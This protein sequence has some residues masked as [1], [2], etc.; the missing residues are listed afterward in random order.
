MPEMICPFCKKAWPQD[1]KWCM[2]DGS[3]LEQNIG[4][5]EG[6]IEEGVEG[7]ITCPDCGKPIDPR[8][9]FCAGC[10]VRL[11]TAEEARAA[12]EKLT[13]PGCGGAVA[14]AEEFCGHCGAALTEEA[15]AAQAA[16]QQP[17]PAANII[18]PQCSLELPAGS[19]Y[20]HSCGYQFVKTQEEQP[21]QQAAFSGMGACPNCGMEVQPGEA[22][23]GTCGYNMGGAAA[24][25][26]PV[27]AEQ[28]ALPPAAPAAGAACPNCG[29]AV[30]PGETFCGNCGNPM[31]QAA[32]PEAAAPQAAPP[33]ATAAGSC[34][35]CG[36][37]VQP[38][39]A[40]CGTCGYNMGGAAAPAAPVA[41]EQPALPPAA[42][43]AGAACPNCGM[44]VQPGE[45]FCGNCG[46]P[47]AQAPAPEAAAPQAAAP[48]APEAA[49][50]A[51]PSDGCPQCGMEID[52]GENI[53]STCGYELT[54][55]AAAAP[56]PEAAAP[57]AAAPPAPEAA[58]PAAPSGGCPQCGMEMEPGETICST[59]GYELTAAAAPAPAPQPGGIDLDAPEM[60]VSEAKIALRCP[61]CGSTRMA[62]GGMFCAVCGAMVGE[63]DGPSEFAADEAGA[64][65]LPDGVT[66][67]DLGDPFAQS[68]PAPDPDQAPQDE[69][70]MPSLGD[71]TGSDLVCPSCGLEGYPGH[72]TCVACGTPLTTQSEVVAATASTLHAAPAPE[73][74]SDAPLEPGGEEP[75]DEYGAPL[76]PSGPSLGDITGDVLVCS[77]CGFEAMP[78]AEQCTR[79][80][81]SFI[82]VAEEMDRV[83]M[84]T[85]PAP[86]P[87]A[88][89]PAAVEPA[90]ATPQPDA[91]GEG[92]MKICSCCGTPS[93]AS[94]EFCSN[95][96]VDFD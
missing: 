56:A 11:Q 38:G 65:E 49:A 88:P 59:C 51:A 36:M 4:Q 13:C 48:P 6:E 18:C 85:V 71:V 23:C 27:A 60:Q 29:M 21:G 53:C 58:A 89:A 68:A 40:F 69:A 83:A 39:E 31:A 77:Q 8:D 47:M 2:E 9:E 50:P 12:T 20:C 54:P 24:P 81:G 22:F 72:E 30:Q 43:A 73:P 10:G 52:P 5:Y 45:T 37:E 78:G 55:A 80:G 15:A 26:A 17:P 35:Q 84:D 28:P 64:G 42:P 86:E 7:G 14:P 16:Q 62:Q 46:N 87:E 34:P 44:A 95:C 90:P 3:E 70:P 19:V 33:A 92:D 82:T 67:G 79:C 61:E 74:A 94:E 25:A 1:F 93:P 57:Q 32:A 91:G 96:G 75:V 76:P 63:D 66:P 41:A